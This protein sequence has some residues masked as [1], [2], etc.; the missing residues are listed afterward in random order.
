[1]NNTEI[2]RKK[3][4]VGFAMATASM[5]FSCFSYGQEQPIA[6]EDKDKAV[7]E[8]PE[9]K[10]IQENVANEEVKVEDK[11][12]LLE[13]KDPF[14]SS[15]PTK[16]IEVV[17][18]KEPEAQE[19]TDTFNPSSLRISG[20]VWG[21]SKPKAIINDQVIGIGDV[22]EDAEVLNI[23][24]EGILVKYSDKEYLLKRSGLDFK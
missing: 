22:I 8:Q 18:T 6:A 9:L 14:V 17:E 4:I 13:Y 20:M 2:L 5:F 10:E 12:V 1:M 11:R 19:A 16:A 15:L 3:I 24:A 7:L 23:T 21:E